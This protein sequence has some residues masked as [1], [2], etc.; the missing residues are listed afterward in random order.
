MNSFCKAMD[1]LSYNHTG[2]GPK[3]S[4]TENWLEKITLIVHI[5]YQYISYLLTF[6]HKLIQYMYMKMI[7][8]YYVLYFLMSF[9]N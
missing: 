7:K 9:N 1:T 3:F 5:L 8:F 2:V 6:F 4:H